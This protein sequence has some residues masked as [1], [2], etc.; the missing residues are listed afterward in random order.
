MKTA[1]IIALYR[2]PQKPD[3][4]IVQDLAD[5]L[6]GASPALDPGVEQDCLDHLLDLM[7]YRPGVVARNFDA[8]MYEFQQRLLA[9]EISRKTG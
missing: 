4:E 8:A 2:A 9:R 3:A 5:L 7:Q 6:D 1:D